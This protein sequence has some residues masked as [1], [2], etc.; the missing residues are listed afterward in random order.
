MRNLLIALLLVGSCFAADHT[1]LILAP[2]PP[3]TGIATWSKAG[4]QSRHA[5]IYLAGEYPSGFAF[6]SQIKDKDVDKIKAAGT[7]VIILDSQYTRA[8]LDAAKGQ[9]VPPVKAKKAAQ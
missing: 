5:M 3:P 1:C 6:R 4:A 7:Q 9:C 8:D 2:A